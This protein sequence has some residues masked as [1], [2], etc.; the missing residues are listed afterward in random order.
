M[1]VD[2]CE[3]GNQVFLKKG[4]GEGEKKTDPSAYQLS[5]FPL[6]LAVS[7][8][9]TP[10]ENGLLCDGFPGCVVTI[11]D[12]DESAGRPVVDTFGVTRD[13]PFF[14]WGSSYSITQ[15][16]AVLGLGG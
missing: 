6:G 12:R 11:R 13:S 10:R 14:W 3:D 4:G 2:F 5:A 9:R 8:F 16:H 1:L 15:S 7:P